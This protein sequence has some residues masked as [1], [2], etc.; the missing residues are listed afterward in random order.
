MGARA[1]AGARRSEEAREAPRA[2]SGP[3]L[4]PARPRP[5]AE[6]CLV[7]AARASGRVTLHSGADG[8]GGAELASFRAAPP[9]VVAGRSDGA[10]LELRGLRLVQ[11]G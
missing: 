2:H 4:T 1:V 6:R 7:A 11:T 10:A 8:R 9:P 3:A 5:Y